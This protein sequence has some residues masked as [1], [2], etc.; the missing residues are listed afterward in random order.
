LR[1][2]QQ[3]KG[4]WRIRVGDEDLCTDDG[5]E[6]RITRRPVKA[7]DAIDAADIPERH[8]GIAE[9]RRAIGEVFGIGGRLEEREGALAA[10][11]DIV[12][13]RKGHI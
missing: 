3:E 1:L 9:F 4:S 7:G 2:D 6:P 8:R 10:E 11:F 13:R 12:R 5:S